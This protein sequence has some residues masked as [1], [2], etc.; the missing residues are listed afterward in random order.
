MLKIALS[1]RSVV[2]HTYCNQ[3]CE[4]KALE[5]SYEPGEGLSCK[6]IHNLWY[7][8]E[9]GWYKLSDEIAYF[10]SGGGIFMDKIMYSHDK[11]LH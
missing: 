11:S 2:T 3:P 10:E 4:S 5:T 7:N 1:D 9:V 8:K 6:T